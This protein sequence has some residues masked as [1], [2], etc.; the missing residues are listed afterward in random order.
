MI[1]RFFS[2]K[3]NKVMRKMIEIFMLQKCR[4]IKMILRKE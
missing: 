4:R 1:L 3:L 2:T